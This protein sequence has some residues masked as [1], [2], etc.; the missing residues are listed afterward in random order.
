MEALKK[1]KQNEIDKVKELLNEVK[2][3]KVDPDTTLTFNESGLM[4]NVYKQDSKNIIISNKRNVQK[5]SANTLDFIPFSYKTD[6]T[7]HSDSTANRT[8][9][10]NIERRI[11]EFDAKVKIMKM[12]VPR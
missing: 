5:P 2:D 1:Q 4:E 7:D 9:I 12:E 10:D 8:V 3:D 6:R 11:A